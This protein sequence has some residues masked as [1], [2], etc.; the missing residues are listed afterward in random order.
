MFLEL[1]QVLINP[2]GFKIFFEEITN[3]P[4]LPD[5]FLEFLQILINPQSFRIFFEVFTKTPELPEVAGHVSR[6]STSPNKSP[7]LQNIF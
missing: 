7:K 3:T 6:I 4:R 5:M 2:Q 1:L